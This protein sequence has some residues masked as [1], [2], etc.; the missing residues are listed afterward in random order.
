[1]TATTDLI[2]AVLGEWQGVSRTWFEPGAP[3]DESPISGKIRRIG[4]GRF[5]LHEYVSAFGGEAREGVEIIGIGLGGADGA[6]GEEGSS[7]VSAWVDTFHMSQ[8]IMLSRGERAV[9]GFSVLGSYSDPTGGPAWDWRTHLE[10][11][12]MDQLVITAYNIKPGEE[13]AKAVETVYSRR[14]N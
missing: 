3:V 14:S 5:V 1:M 4:D 9:G 12:D 13:E 8:D 2:Q 7:F 10:V 6:E 11:K